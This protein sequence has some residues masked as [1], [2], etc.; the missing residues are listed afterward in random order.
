MQT[1]SVVQAILTTFS[2]LNSNAEGNPMQNI[3]KQLYVHLNI[4]KS[5][6]NIFERSQVQTSILHYHESFEVFLKVFISTLIHFFKSFSKFCKTAFFLLNPPN[7]KL[8]LASAHPVS[9]ILQTNHSITIKISH[10][11]WT[12]I[13]GLHDKDRSFLHPNN[14]YFMRKVPYF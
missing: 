10:K 5:F 4:A 1:V 12:V 13:N 3:R 6:S 11:I 14:L 8:K 7:L 9:L 2:A